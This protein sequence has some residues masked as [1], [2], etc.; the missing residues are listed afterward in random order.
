MLYEAVR[1]LLDK[2]S[3]TAYVKTVRDNSPDFLGS[4]QV[5]LSLSL[6]FGTADL[7]PCPAKYDRIEYRMCFIGG[8]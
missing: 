5:L 6:S 1:T 7:I 4:V 3:A 2:G 8:G